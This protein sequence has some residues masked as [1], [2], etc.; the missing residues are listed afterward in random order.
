MGKLLPPTVARQTGI[1]GKR[2]HV[3]GKSH[4]RK[5][6][7]SLTNRKQSSNRAD[8]SSQDN[9]TQQDTEYDEEEIEEEERHYQQTGVMGRSYSIRGS[10]YHSDSDDNN[11]TENHLYPDSGSED[12][13]PKKERV[14]SNSQSAVRTSHQGS[15]V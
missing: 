3:V 4:I 15:S 7:T 13:Q 11:D 2:Q 8:N 14:Y 1:L 9:H 6:S 10:E 12:G 5:Q